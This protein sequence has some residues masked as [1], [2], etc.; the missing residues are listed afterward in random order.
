V[1]RLALTCLICVI[2]AGTAAAQ[3]VDEIVARHVEARGN[4]AQW[5]AVRTIRM[6]GRA[7]AGPGREALVTREIKRPG[8]V[9]TE[10][11]FQGIT[12]VFAFDGK[13]GWQISPLTGILTPTEMAPDDTLAAVGQADLDGPLAAAR[14]QGSVLTLVGRE[15]IAGRDAFR[16]RVTPKGG[17]ALEQYL[18]AETFLIVR[19]DSTRT[20]GGQAVLVETTF[21][22]YRSIGGLVFPHTI[23]MGARG[24]PTRVRVVVETIEINLSIE[25]SRFRAPSGTRKQEVKSEK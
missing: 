9:R 12:G 20:V 5:Q 8:R 6:T 25:D 13:R 3:T 14:K 22:D 16:I 10:F 7:I 15:T 19:T 4:A 1:I 23:E 24:R 2:T 11:T 18:D 17:S 21:G